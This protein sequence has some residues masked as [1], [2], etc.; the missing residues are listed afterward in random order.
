MG[1]HSIKRMFERVGFVS[2]DTI[3]IIIDRIKA[4]NVVQK[5][6]WKGF[7]QL[8]YTVKE[9]GDPERYKI[10]LSFKPVNGERYI[11]VITVS[12]V[13]SEL[14]PPRMEQRMNEDPRIAEM[15]KKIK[16]RYKKR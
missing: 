7:P 8:S 6:Q 12:N 4:T 10:S 16:E 14:S 9:N 11:R 13:P 1:K 3:V 15:L 2:R 5:A